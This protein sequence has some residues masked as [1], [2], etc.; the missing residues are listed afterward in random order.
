MTV[1]TDKTAA[2]G[3]GQSMRQ[4]REAAGISREKLAAQIGATAN[5]VQRWES[6]ESSPTFATVVRVAQIIDA[7]LDDLAVAITSNGCYTRGPLR[8]VPPIAG[9]GELFDPDLPP[10]AVACAPLAAAA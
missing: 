4:A 8:L 6:G 1:G 7:D 9:Q 3:L 2:S 5:T 10:A